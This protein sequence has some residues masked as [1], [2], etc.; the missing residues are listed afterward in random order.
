MHVDHLTLACLRDRLDSLLGA[1]VQRAVQVDERSIGL[2]LYAG[3]RFQ[4]LISAQSQHARMLL[5]PHKLRRGVETPTPLLLLLRKWV[6]GARL[7]D[8]TQPAWERILTLHFEGEPGTC[9]LVAE[10]IDRYSNIILVDGD[11][12]VM[13]ALKRVGP[14]QNRYRVTLP[15][16]PY[17]PP[18]QPPGRRPPTAPTPNDVAA[19]LAA[20]DPQEPV[21]YLFTRRFFA[22]SPTAAR[23]VVARVAGHPEA[24]VEAVAP[25]PL[26]TAINRLFAPLEDGSWAPHV[27][28]DD[29]GEVSAFAPYELRQFE[30]TEP[31]D[32]ISR[33]MWRY[34]RRA[35]T[36]DAYAAIRQKV[37]HALADAQARVARALE[38]V[39]R[40]RVEPAEVASLR[41][42]GELLL[43]YQGRVEPGA[44]EVTVPDYAG[45]PR[46]IALDPELTPVENAQAYFERYRK[47]ERAAKQIPPRLRAL[48]A[49]RAYLAQ[50]ATDLDLAESRPEIDA[51]YEALREAGWVSKPSRHHAGQV[52][53]PRHVEID[54]A[55]LYVGRNAQ[56]NEEVT[57]ERA[58]R[59]DLWLH[60]RG[61]PGAHVIVKSDKAPSETVVRRAAE[62]AAYFS[63]ARDTGQ[64]AVDVVARRF[65]KRAPGGRPGLVTYRN[66]ETVWVD[67]GALKR[68]ASE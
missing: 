22:I 67:S 16:Q 53:G 37:R 32:Y 65:V 33:A 3:E 23:E 38:Q 24:P 10:L 44:N 35:L 47:A 20:A 48:K 14:D 66:E 43:T 7:V 36:A 15:G 52:K 12:V 17:Q 45:E 62:L 5:V 42:A 63:A 8:L 34:F 39:A 25:E 51:V 68:R 64:V 59:D 56:Q 18:P 11:G 55:H 54:G 40:Q 30:R 19:M 28:L 49:D 4:L 13:D 27:A 6:R 21:R 41:Q 31:V 60:V 58:D 1:R 2:E 46:T 9:R 61:V 26:H 50:L 29:E 57:F